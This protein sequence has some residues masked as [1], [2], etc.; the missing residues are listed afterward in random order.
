[1]RRLPAG[2]FALLLAGAAGRAQ[3][4][5]SAGVLEVVVAPRDPEDAP[6]LDLPVRVAAARVSGEGP[7]DPAAILASKGAKSGRAA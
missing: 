2:L 1:M 3:D 6:P 4:A 7:F 5:P